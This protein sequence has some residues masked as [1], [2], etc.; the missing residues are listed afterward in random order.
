[1]VKFSIRLI[2]LSL[3][4]LSQQCLCASYCEDNPQTGEMYCRFY[5]ATGTPETTDDSETL[6]QWFEYCRT[7]EFDGEE[8]CI[9]MGEKSEPLDVEIEF[10]KANKFSWLL[11]VTNYF[12]QMEDFSDSIE[13]R[14]DDSPVRSLNGAGGNRSKTGKDAYVRVRQ[15]FQADKK[16]FEDIAGAESLVWLRFNQKDGSHRDLKLDASYFS[17]LDKFL[18]E[19]ESVHGTV[20][21]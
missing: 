11:I 9:V 15:I 4:L 17:S 16:L 5:V 14:V 13:I 18:L 19:V 2:V 6:L 7:D 20:D 21:N 8:I 3:L 1:M 12:D 10:T